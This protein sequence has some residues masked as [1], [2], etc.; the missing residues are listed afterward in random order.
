METALRE[1]TNLGSEG[2]LRAIEGYRTWYLVSAMGWFVVGI[3]FVICGLKVGQFKADDCDDWNV[4]IRYVAM[5]LILF[6]GVAMMIYNLSTICAPEAY[7][8]HCFIQD[9]KP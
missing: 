3:A 7:A 9:I 1:L 5:S 8:I 4:W 6:I 2:V